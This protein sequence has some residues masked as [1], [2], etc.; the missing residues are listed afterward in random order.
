MCLTAEAYRERK[1]GEFPTLRKA[2]EDKEIPSKYYGL[3]SA[4]DDMF[5]HMIRLSHIAVLA[6]ESENDIKQVAALVGR[7][8]MYQDLHKLACDLDHFSRFFKETS[9]RV[10]SLY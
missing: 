5:D 2:L 3:T 8:E 1:W 4:S 9:D 7:G 10:R 6:S